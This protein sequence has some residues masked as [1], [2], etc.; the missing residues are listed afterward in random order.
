MKNL[1]NVDL[2]LLENAPSRTSL[3]WR[4]SESKQRLVDRYRWR[5]YYHGD[6]VACLVRRIIF[7]SIGKHKSTI[8]RKLKEVTPSA[9]PHLYINNWWIK[10]PKDCSSYISS[11]GGYLYYDENNYLREE[12]S[13][14]PK[15][16]KDIQEH[17]RSKERTR[18]H[19][20]E[21]QQRKAHSL[22]LLK[23]INN[24]PLF[25]F[26]CKLVDERKAHQK[27][28]AAPRPKELRYSWWT[29]NW[30]IGDWKRSKE[31]AEKQLPLLEQQIQAIENGDY[32][33]YYESKGY[34]H[35][36][37]KECPHMESPTKA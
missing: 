36:I 6:E 26:Y 35:S 19:K 20:L 27:N 15:K 12:P 34:L 8:D 7:G 2:E 24:K 29:W 9:M 1:K 33:P 23:L 5:F 3:R 18:Q 25:D 37:G 16:Y 30:E 4:M 22:V 11:F 14:Y 13:T 21:E 10:N 17:E 31:R 32:T 28:L